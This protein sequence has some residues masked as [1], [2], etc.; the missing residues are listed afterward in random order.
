MNEHIQELLPGSDVA[1][2]LGCTCSAE[3]ELDEECPLHGVW[4]TYC[5]RMTADDTERRDVA[6][7]SGLPSR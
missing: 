4:R 7:T 3:D 5:D 6:V 2:R 1:V